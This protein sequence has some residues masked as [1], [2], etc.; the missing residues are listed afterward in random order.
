MLHW[1]DIALGGLQLYIRVRDRLGRRQT[2]CE[3]LLRDFNPTLVICVHVCRPSDPRRV[4]T[5]RSSQVPGNRARGKIDCGD[6][7][8]CMSV[9]C[10]VVDPPKVKNEAADQHCTNPIIEA[11]GSFIKA[12]RDW[13]VIQTTHSSA[14]DMT[15]VHPKLPCFDAKSRMRVIK[16]KAKRALKLRHQYELLRDDATN[17][18]YTKYSVPIKSVSTIYRRVRTLRAHHLVQVGLSALA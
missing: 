3:W 9:I 13:Q 18:T 15:R 6:Q 11:K 17:N 8:A 7:V 2:S 14:M 5:K 1:S 12:R 10:G 16:F 4:S